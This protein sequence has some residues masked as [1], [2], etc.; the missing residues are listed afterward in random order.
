M[1]KFKYFILLLSVIC[2]SNA[3]DMTNWMS[4]L[5]NT[6][7]LNYITLPGSHDA[8]M[9]K[10]R[11][12]APP[13]KGA[14]LSQTQDLDILDQ[15]TA[16]VRYFDIRPDYDKGEL[17][18]YHRYELAGFGWGCSGQDLV[19]IF[20]QAVNFLQEHPSEV[21]IFRIS[22]TRDGSGHLA[23]DTVHRVI[24]LISQRQYNDHLYKTKEDQLNIAELSLYS[25]RGKLLIVL[26]EEYSAYRDTERGLFGYHN[27]GDQLSGL[28]V[29]D[30]YANTDNLA[31]MIKDQ[32]IKLSKFGGLGK[33]YLFLLSWT[34]TVQNF[35]TTSSIRS[36]SEKANSALAGELNSLSSKGYPRPN[37]VYLDFIDPE[38]VNSVVRLNYSSIF[39]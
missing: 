10:A 8:G 30:Q 18:T 17:V 2:S 33:P 12:C 6:T 1:Q 13:I 16:G 22:K 5:D 27:Y 15:L 20:D 32:Q 34:L 7:P 3:L 31:T 29:F 36:L 28:T 39:N 19:S 26:G 35:L 38:L 9:S 25:V 4:N 23:S 14:A 11:N 24:E 37:I 21:V